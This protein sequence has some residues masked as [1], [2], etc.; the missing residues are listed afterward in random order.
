MRID[1]AVMCCSF[2]VCSPLM[3]SSRCDAIANN[4]GVDGMAFAAMIGMCA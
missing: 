3:V 2:D 4:T 1:V